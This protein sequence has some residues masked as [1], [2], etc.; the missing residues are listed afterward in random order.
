M[1]GQLSLGYIVGSR[2]QT[3]SQEHLNSYMKQAGFQYR[4]VDWGHRDHT[5]YGGF[6]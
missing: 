4:K 5:T 2:G 1:F 3:L 6:E